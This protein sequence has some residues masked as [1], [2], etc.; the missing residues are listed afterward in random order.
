MSKHKGNSVRAACLALLVL[1]VTPVLNGC[2]TLAA[3]GMAT[4]TLAATDRRTVGTQVEDRGIQLKTSGKASS[5]GDDVHVNTTVYNR[6]VLITG[7]VPDEATKAAV[8]REIATV[9]NVQY[10]INELVVAGKTSLTS[11]SNDTLITGKVK[12]AMIDAKD[13]FASAF[14]ITTE[15][16]TVYLMGLVTAREAQRAA[17][18][19]AAVA[20]VERVVKITDTISEN[21]LQKMTVTPPAKQ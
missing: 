15:R 1:A 13:V 5:F 3:A 10:V 7:E 16:G 21:E 2:F 8:E 12:A 14:K 20:G 4:G 9:E 19:A 17:E 18:V 11:R 6:R